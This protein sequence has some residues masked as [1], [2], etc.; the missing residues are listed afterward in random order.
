MLLATQNRH[1]LRSV[2]VG[3]DM[4][5]VCSCS[6][7]GI[8]LSQCLMRYWDPDALPC[9]ILSAARTLA[10]EAS[11]G[12]NGAKRLFL[13]CMSR[14]PAVKQVDMTDYR[15]NFSVG[16]MSVWKSILYFSNIWANFIFAVGQLKWRPQ[17]VFNTTVYFWVSDKCMINKVPQ[18]KHFL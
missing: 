11:G 9:S 18:Y 15:N 1:R 12:A 4:C 8:V 6:Q 10:V 14:L 7:G 17:N 13:Q 5:G 16:V 2:C 3:V